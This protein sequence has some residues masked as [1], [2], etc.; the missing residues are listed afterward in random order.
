[1][2]VE[3]PL[4][5]G[6]KGGMVGTMVAGVGPPQVGSVSTTVYG[7][8]MGQLEGI[9]M[10]MGGKDIGPPPTITLWKGFECA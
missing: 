10:M 3:G 5:L 6:I 9:P 8:E 4:L 7:V 1:M 2:D